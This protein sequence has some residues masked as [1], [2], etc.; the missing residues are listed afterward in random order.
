MTTQL[1]T[2]TKIPSKKMKRTKIDHKTAKEFHFEDK[3]ETASFLFLQ[4]DDHR[5]IWD[6]S[7]ADFS[8]LTFSEVSCLY[9]KGVTGTETASL[10]Q[11]QFLAYCLLMAKILQNSSQ[12]PILSQKLKIKVLKKCASLFF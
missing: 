8:S 9:M 7:V 1:V 4:E 6:I 12:V 2:L 5:V 10:S 11:M 3:K